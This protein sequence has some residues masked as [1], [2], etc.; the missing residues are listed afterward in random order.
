MLEQ[1]GG[2][3]FGMSSGLEDSTIVTVRQ[4]APR[5]VYQV[6]YDLDYGLLIS[7]HRIFTMYTLNKEL[8]CAE[9]VQAQ[10]GFVSVLE[11]AVTV[12]EIPLDKFICMRGSS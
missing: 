9:S 12:R 7:P 10:A 8:A 1:E 4:L 5:F 6:D 3:N 2:R 11:D